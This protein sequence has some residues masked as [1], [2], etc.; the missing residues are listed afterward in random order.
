MDKETKED[1]GF[2]ALSL[3]WELGYSIA[4]PLVVLALA[5]R[6]L[7]KKLD[8]APFLLLAGILVS[9]FVSSYMVYKKTTD[10]MDRK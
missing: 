8:T 9:I 4:V 2:S 1:N 5:G 6:F 10:I 3:A 7:D